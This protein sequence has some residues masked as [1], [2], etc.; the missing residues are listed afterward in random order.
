M[1]RR[2]P[3]IFRRFR[4]LSI[5]MGVYTPPIEEPKMNGQTAKPSSTAVDIVGQSDENP[6]IPNVTDGRGHAKNESPAGEETIRE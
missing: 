6:P 1:K 4:T 5:A 3:C 2:N